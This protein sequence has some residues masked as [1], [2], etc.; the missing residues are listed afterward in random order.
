MIE[1]LATPA[2]AP[3]CTAVDRPTQR[4]LLVED[5]P[6]D[7][8][9]LRE[10]LNEEGTRGFELTEVRTMA[11]AEQLLAQHNVDIVL[12][13]LGLPDATGLGALSRAMTAAPRIP[14]VVLTGLDDELLATQALHGGAQDYLIKGEISTRALLRA[15][16]YAVERKCMEDALLDEKERVVAMNE[17]LVI[18]SALQLRLTESGEKLNALLKNEISVG[19]L[20]QQGLIEK[21]LHI[22]AALREKDVL[23]GEIHHRVKNNLQIINSLLELQCSQ[24]EDPVVL[25]MLRDSQNRIRSMA[26]IHQTLYQSN[27]FGRVDFGH[28]LDSLV[29]TLIASY[30]VDP[31]RI[32]LHVHAEGIHLPIGA[33]IPCGLLVNELISNALKHAFPNGRSGRIDIAFVPEAGDSVALTISDDGVGIPESLDL[34]DMV[35]LGLQLVFL[36]ADQLRATIAVHRS[37]P[38]SFILRFCLGTMAADLPL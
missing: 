23:L 37:N 14:L 33:A 11:D 20:A 9:L 10:M 13:D 16:H 5:N 35:S 17:A 21:E 18:G 29:P 7:A 31:E 3:T 28:F 12:L 32:S 2:E 27:A 34:T 4:L 36:L 26:L 6:G 25:V 38:T 8:R 22:E 24:I 30:L 15:L 19:K 1:Q